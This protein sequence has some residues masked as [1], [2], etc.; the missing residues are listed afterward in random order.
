MPEQPGGRGADEPSDKQKLLRKMR[1]YAELLGHDAEQ[2]G[3][4]LAGLRICGSLDLMDSQGSTQAV[5]C[6]T[7]N[8]HAQV[9]AVQEWL[10]DHHSM[11][12]GYSEAQGS[13]DFWDS[14]GPTD[15]GPPQLP[16]DE[17]MNH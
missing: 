1:H 11:L 2:L 8:F 9:A 12:R 7:G 10:D 14:Q 15:D 5:H 6:G 13:K 16:G 3:F 17:W 4:N